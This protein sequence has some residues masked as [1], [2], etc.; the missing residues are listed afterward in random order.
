MFWRHEK[1]C[2]LHHHTQV[3]RHAVTRTPKRHMGRFTESPCSRGEGARLEARI[4]AGRLLCLDIVQ[5]VF[6][7]HENYPP[8]F[9]VDFQV[10]TILLEI[11]QS[12]R[13]EILALLVR[14]SLAVH[15]GPVSSCRSMVSAFRF[16]PENPKKCI[17]SLTYVPLCAFS[18]EF[19]QSPKHA[20]PDQVL[21]SLGHVTV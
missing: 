18:F 7:E 16:R 10:H 14:E 17:F 19:T 2:Y 3:Y 20:E 5:C 11:P 12:F 13:A 9:A 4:Q 15:A 6:T 21:Q 8:H 1:K